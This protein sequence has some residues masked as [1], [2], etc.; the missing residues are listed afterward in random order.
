MTSKP[1]VS[2]IMNCYNGQAYL[3]EA[4]NSIISQTYQNWE[5]IFWDNLSTDNS[6]KIFEDFKDKRFK[7]FLSKEHTVL[8]HARNLAIRKT[9]GEFLAFLDTDDMWV[10]NKL[11]KQISLFEKDSDI[12]LV[13]G[14]CWIH[15][16][17]NIIKKTKIF[18]KKLLPTGNIT[19]ALFE[20]YKVGLLTIMIRKSYLDNFDN[21]FSVKYDLLSDFDFVIKFSLKAKIDC[22]QEPVAIYRRHKNQL[23]RIYSHKQIEQ[24]EK[25]Y[26]NIKNFPELK[27]FN[28]MPTLEKRIKYLKILKLINEKRYLKSFISIFNFPMSLTKIKLI[29]IL[30]LPNFIIKNFVDII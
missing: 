11:E 14:N 28:I 3:K 23:Q 5:L 19:K 12:G 18:S 8:Y 30:L 29:L 25:W 20:D 7:Y 4:L 13:Y 21:V 24:L 15:T 2:I 9:A 6:R 26:S 16:E 1:L 10:S 27:S 22:V 17:K